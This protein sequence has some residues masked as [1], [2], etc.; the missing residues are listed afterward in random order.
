MTGMLTGVCPTRCSVATI[1]LS[2]TLGCSFRSST[3]WPL[4]GMKI[5]TSAR[6]FPLSERSTALDVPS[7]VVP[8]TSS[9]VNALYCCR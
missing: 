9:G 2:Y 5:P 7:A 3:A 4:K 6:P 8:G 1:A